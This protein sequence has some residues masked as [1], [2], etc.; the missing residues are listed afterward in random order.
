MLKLQAIDLEIKEKTKEIES[1]PEE[2]YNLRKVIEQK[3][4]EA[5]EIKKKH[6]SIKVE[7]RQQEAEL[8]IIEDQIK[9]FQ[10]KQNNVKTNK[11]Y[12][13]LKDEV[14]NFKKKDSSI[15]DVILSLIESDEKLAEQEKEFSMLIEK[16]KKHLEEKEEE[17]K[18]KTEESKKVLEQKST[19]REPFLKNID[20][21][22]L[23]VYEKIRKN[24]KDGIAIVEIAR[25]EKGDICT[26]CNVYI[27]SY[28]AEK[29]RKSKEI[30]QCENCGRILY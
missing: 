25:E 17:I 14:E 1:F 18:Q 29:I 7:R 21:Q 12:I 26:G 13:A 28:L 4:K 19:E 15:E 24:K 20:S 5:D 2:L 10:T 11:E 6:T 9:S 23:D 22:N 30:V 27:P 3:Q 8:K 16:E